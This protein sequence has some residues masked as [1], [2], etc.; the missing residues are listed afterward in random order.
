MPATTI[1]LGSEARLPGD[2]AAGHALGMTYELH[3]LPDENVLQSDLQIAI[4]AYRAL[5]FRGGF[6]LT[7]DEGL[8]VNKLATQSLLTQ[9]NCRIASIAR[10]RDAGAISERKAEQELKQAGEFRAQLMRQIDT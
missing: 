1:D 6:E 8:E 2:Y 9:V 4:R 3:K 7:N 10:L 5:T